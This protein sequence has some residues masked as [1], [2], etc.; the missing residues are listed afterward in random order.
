[1]TRDVG[2][3]AAQ[4]TLFPICINHPHDTGSRGLGPVQVIDC[5]VAVIMI[6][7]MLRP[8]RLLNINCVCIIVCLLLIYILAT[9][10]VI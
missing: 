4:G 1:M 8:E 5:M 6:L 9:S 2:L 10:K 7:D 3:I